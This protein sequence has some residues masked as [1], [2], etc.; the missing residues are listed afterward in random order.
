MGSGVRLAAP[1]L[2]WTHVR[3][4]EDVILP[5]D[6]M[7]PAAHTKQALLRGNVMFR[8]GGIDESDS[9]E[10]VV[11]IRLFLQFPAFASNY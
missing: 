2:K 7:Q 5:L 9:L 6:V 1:L 10:E 4:A 11:S 8:F 3:F